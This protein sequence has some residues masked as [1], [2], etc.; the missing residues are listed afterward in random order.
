MWELLKKGNTSSLM[1]ALGNTVV[2]VMKGVAA[3]FTGSSAMFAS[4]VHSVADAV[5]QG[6]VYTGSVLAE[7][8]PTRKFPTGFGR[9][10]NV[11]VMVAVIVVTIMAVVTIEE[12]WH[13]IQEP[14]PSGAVWLNLI[15]LLISMLIDGA[16][17]VKAMK[18]VVQE[19]GVQEQ[20]GFL[21]TKSVRNLRL[22][23]PPTRLVFYEDCV[24]TLGALFALLAIAFAP[25]TGWYELEGVAA[26]LIGCLLL[27]IAF[28]LGYDNMVGLIGVA[29][30]K[31]IE[32]RVAEIIFS[33]PD[34]VDIN[35]MRVVQEGRYYHVEAYIEL[36]KGL[37]LAQAD[38]I[39]M[40]VQYTLMADKNI[41]DAT[42]GIMEDNDV[43]D[44]NPEEDHVWS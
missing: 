20:K 9:L 3:S 39:I 38:D 35:K 22:A 42:L 16:V 18:E 8:G 29:A 1:A 14:H 12:G 36:R 13:I 40:R 44:W 19:A 2:A 15:L 23:A 6:F 25:I 24:A 11:F 17:L 43:K 5:N 4:A 41:G 28:K 26:I 21:F 33:D 27:I 7:K 31:V 34:V 32:D 10:V 37:A 30:P